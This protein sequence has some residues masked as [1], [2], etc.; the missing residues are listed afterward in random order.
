[1]KITHY[2]CDCC[3]Q[4]IDATLP[5]DRPSSIKIATSFTKVHPFKLNLDE[6]N[7]ANNLIIFEIE[8]CCY[9]CRRMLSDV[10]TEQIIAIRRHFK[11]ETLKA[12]KTL[13]VKQ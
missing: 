5:A 7:D 10:I 11:V 1:M 6:C 9:S 4:P 8:H 3:H 2:Q 12:D 13:P